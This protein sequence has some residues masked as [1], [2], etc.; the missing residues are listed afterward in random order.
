M[1][2]FS[3]AVKIFFEQSSL[4]STHV[5]KNWPVSLCQLSWCVQEMQV[6]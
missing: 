4:N 5:S 1:S 2:D 6:C 3:G